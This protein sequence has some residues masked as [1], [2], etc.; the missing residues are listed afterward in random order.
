M[1]S[2]AKTYESG[3]PI[4]QLMSPRSWAKNVNAEINEYLLEHGWFNEVE[5]YKR[6]GGAYSL[7]PSEVVSMP[8]RMRELELYLVANGWSDD[9]SRPP[10]YR[11]SRPRPVVVE[12]SSRPSSRDSTQLRLSPRLRC[13]SPSASPN[14]R[15]K[16]LANKAPV[17]CNPYRDCTPSAVLDVSSPR[18]L[19]DLGQELPPPT[20]PPLLMR[21]STTW[22]RTAAV[23]HEFGGVGAA[24]IV[25]TA[26]IAAA[27]AANGTRVNG[28]GLERPDL[29]VLESRVRQTLAGGGESV[30]RG[31]RR[32]K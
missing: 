28:G 32:R 14:L 8:Q 12:R 20:S 16:L 24:A 25:K 7:P 31:N 17:H 21:R 4:P 2:D 11:P 26:R 30:M 10:G 13:G 18:E 3:A 5:D 29:A 23:A 9:Y 15:K 27:A 6:G 22:Q 19:E 1:R